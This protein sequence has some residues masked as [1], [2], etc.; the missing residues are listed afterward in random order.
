MKIKVSYLP[1]CDQVEPIWLVV[2]PV[3]PFVVVKQFDHLFLRPGDSNFIVRDLS[4]LRCKIEGRGGG[5]LLIIIQ[6]PQSRIHV[7][8]G[9]FSQIWLYF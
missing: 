2:D 1:L 5:S 3:A 7:I 6:S 4:P 9:S 8:P